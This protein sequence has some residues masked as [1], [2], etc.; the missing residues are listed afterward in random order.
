[1]HSVMG[2][3]VLVFVLNSASQLEVDTKF[4]DGVLEA[5]AQKQQMINIECREDFTDVPILEVS[6]T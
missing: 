6:Y 1:M 3:T 2:R 5:G 4:D